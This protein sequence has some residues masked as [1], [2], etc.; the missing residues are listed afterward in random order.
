M[1]N[2]SQIV[3]IISLSTFYLYLFLVHLLIGDFND[4]EKTIVTNKIL[5]FRTITMLLAQLQLKRP[6]Y[7]EEG[8]AWEVQRLGSISDRDARQGVR[9]CDALTHLA[10][11][12]RDIIAVAT[13]SNTQATSSESGC[14]DR[15]YPFAKNPCRD[16]DP[17]TDG[18]P[19]ITYPKIISAMKPEDMG[20][21]ML[22]DYIENLD[23]RL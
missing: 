21:Q 22:N 3:R 19:I 12:Q 7:S 23:G 4:D 17:P 13:T 15:I 18:D 2:K 20:S 9:I 10:S 14:D 6:P 1:S 11:R 5:A 8:M 16:D